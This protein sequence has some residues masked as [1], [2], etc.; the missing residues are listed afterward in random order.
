MSA[1]VDLSQRIADIVGVRPVDDDDRALIAA[2]AETAQSWSDL[3]ADVQA[4]LGRLA[5][6]PTLE[7]LLSGRPAGGSLVPV[8][9]DGTPLAAAGRS[10][11]DEQHDV[12]RDSDGR[13]A[14]HDAGGSPFPGMRAATEQDRAAFRDKVG[15]A[16]PPAWTDVYIAD[17][18][19]TAKLLA[20]GRD[21]KGRHQ[22]IYSAA[23]TEAQAAVKFSRIRELAKHLDKLDHA[24]ERDAA[25]NDDAAALLLIRRL[26]MRPGSDRDTGAAQQ[27]HGA[28]NLLA[29]HVTVDG[30]QVGF[31]FTG[32]K[33][34]HIR[35]ST[36][37][38]L[39][40]DAIAARLARRGPDERLFDTDENRTRAYM[41]S[42]GVPTDLLLKDLRTL[43]ANVVALREIQARDGTPAS[44]A[45][46]RRWRKE[47]AE[48][49]AAELGNTPALA[50]AS[51]IN[52]TVFHRW[53]ESEEWL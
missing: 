34:V 42:T 41:H 30:D 28:T 31:D 50:L 45:E 4:L 47:V 18:L 1:A 40:A 27:A 15:Q 7:E 10:A 33:G 9:D 6:E 38:P 23:H 3:P 8:D 39:I 14:E 21:S 43:H 20:R 5:S 29:R 12:H 25:S 22:T 17:D 46:F 37:D 48:Q 44:K 36:S 2:A 51:Y 24:L 35:L 53:A 49:V 19:A 32:K 26:G 16:I 52:P 11:Y 13:F